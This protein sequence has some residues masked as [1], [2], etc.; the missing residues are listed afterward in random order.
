MIQKLA[1]TIAK[2]R[3]VDMVSLVEKSLRLNPA[4]TRLATT[5]IELTKFI[6]IYPDI[7]SEFLRK[8][9]LIQLIIINY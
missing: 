2:S 6:L 1:E 9:S 8:R 4:V 5:A 3:A 7:K